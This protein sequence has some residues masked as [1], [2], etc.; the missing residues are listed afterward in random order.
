MFLPGSGP[1]VTVTL[2]RLAGVWEEKE[3]V[4]VLEKEGEGAGE[5]EKACGVGTG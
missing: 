4:V 2:W 5:D 3:E 1:L